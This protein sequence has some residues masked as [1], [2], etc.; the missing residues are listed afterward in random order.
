MKKKKLQLLGIWNEPPLFAWIWHC[1]AAK[2]HFCKLTGLRVHSFTYIK[3][4]LDYCCFLPHALSVLR[5]RLEKLNDS[6]QIKYMRSI[7]QDY[8]ANV[9]P[10]EL[11]LKQYKNSKFRNFKDQ[12]LV[13]FIDSWAKAFSKLTMQVWCAVFL[14]I[15]YPSAQEK[16]VIKIFMGKMR[17]HLGRRHNQSRELEKKL[18]AE[19]GRRINTS[20]NGMFYLFP[21]EIIDA[22][23]KRKTLEPLAQERMKFCVTTDEFGNYRIFAGTRAQKIASKYDLPKPGVKKQTILHG[24]SANPGTVKGRVRKVLLDSEFSRFKSGEILVSLQTMV[25]YLP[26]MKKAQAILTEFGGLTSHAAIV[27]RE[28]GK[29]CIVGIPNLITSLKDGDRVEVDAEKGVVRKI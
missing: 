9:K 28:L 22:L 21:E 13:D 3:D 12:E 17:D 23:K 18:Y 20:F 5:A 24:M 2:E 27:S 10:F 25:H 8:Y 6:D 7:E 11:F 16:S 26:I 4:E 29:P 14:D 19:I 1:D 15:W